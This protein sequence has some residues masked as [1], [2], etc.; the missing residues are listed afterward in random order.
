MITAIGTGIGT[1]DFDIEK[2][3]YHKIIIMTDADVDGA[4]IRT[5]LLTFFYRQMPQL[6][7]RGY[8][9]IAQPPLYKVTRRKREEYV[10]SDAHL[11]Q[12]LLDLGSD[13]L[14]L[15]NAQGDLL[16]DTAALRALL[17][18]LVEVEELSC[19]FVGEVFYSTIFLGCAIRIRALSRVTPPTLKMRRVRVEYAYDDH[20][21][22]KIF[23]NSDLPERHDELFFSTGLRMRSSNSRAMGLRLRICW[24][25]KR[26]DLFS[27]RGE[28]HRGF[29]LLELIGA[30][31]E[32]GRKGMSIQRYM[33]LGEMNPDQPGRRP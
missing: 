1:D 19:S 32:L 14:T 30:V 3:R 31:R 26:D 13:G 24:R 22:Q 18:H 20:D 2:T 4:H 5:L 21:L 15:Q 7:E 9:Y 27:K 11:S 8:V 16:K 33:G 23:E 28:Y 12:I 25:P 29:G 17:A 6:I 10:E